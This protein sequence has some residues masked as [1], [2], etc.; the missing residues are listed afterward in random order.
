LKYTKELDVD[1]SVRKTW[2]EIKEVWDSYD[3][4]TSG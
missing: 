4:Y 1:G 2:K 3:Q